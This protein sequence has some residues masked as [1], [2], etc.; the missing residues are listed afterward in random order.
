MRFLP[1]LFLASSLFAQ[2][3]AQLCGIDGVC[4][5]LDTS[6]IGGLRFEDYKVTNPNASLLNLDVRRAQ[7]VQLGQATQ[8]TLCAVN[9]NANA[10]L[11]APTL[12][13]ASAA[14]EMGESES[15]SANGTLLQEVYAQATV[16]SLSL[17][18][19]FSALQL[20][21]RI[22]RNR[23]S[24]QLVFSYGAFSLAVDQT[25][26]RVTFPTALP[27]DAQT[28]RVFWSLVVNLQNILNA[29]AAY[30]IPNPPPLGR[31]LFSADEVR[32]FADQISRAV[33]AYALPTL[34]P[35]NGDALALYGAEYL[36]TRSAT[37]A[38]VLS[39]NLTTWAKSATSA[40]SVSLKPIALFWPALQQDP[41]VP[42]ADRDAIN[43]WLT[44]LY[45]SNT[46]ASIK[47]IDAISR[48]DNQAF[49]ETVERY[50]VAINQ[51]RADGSIP[52]E[53]QRGPCALT[54][55]NIA[56]GNLISI[57]ESAAAQGYDLYSLSVNDR[58]IH[59]AIQFLLDAYD[60]FPLIA[61]Y[62][63]P[64]AS[65]YLS[66][67]A[68][69]ER[70]L[71]DPS[72]A[73]AWIEIYLARFQNSPLANRL[74]ARASLTGLTNRPL[75]NAV[76]GANTSCLFVGPQEL[77]PVSLPNLDIVSGDN[78][79]AATNS[80][81]PEKLG[82]RVR[83]NSG[84]PLPNVLVNFAVTSGAGTVDAASALTDPFGVATT[85][86]SLGPRSGATKIAASAL[87]IAPVTFTATARGDDPKLSPDGIA[88][89]GGSVPSV[90]T[91]SPGA[92]L[93]IYGADFVAAGL[94]RRVRTEEI[95]AGRLPTL[96]NGVCVL[97][98]TTLAYMLDAYPNQLNVVVPALTGTASQV[99]VVKN[100]GT[101]GEQ[102]TD[103]QAI[104]V[105]VAAP[106]F[107]SFQPTSS[108]NNPVAA[109]DAVTGEFFGPLNLFGGTAKPAK[110][111]D[112]VTVYLTGLGATT[113]AVLPGAVAPGAASVRGVLVL[114]LAG[115]TIAAENILYAGFS[116]G[117]LIYQINFRVPSG[118]PANNQPISVSVDGQSTPVGAYLTLALR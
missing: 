79:T 1:I 54:Y 39:N 35:D 117:S 81:L 25:T 82:A 114:K 2:R 76:S 106:E 89:V 19:G 56:I 24:S 80:T 51:L 98:D 116:P 97:F 60:N 61:K 113:P 47:A 94:G 22:S 107:F 109:V 26:G 45:K 27:A 72:A 48:R 57:A 3:S 74:R 102:R 105:A 6:R 93:S 34:N 52:E 73:V 83:G 50:F 16:S 36:A 92:I 30:K 43:T 100:C 59:L 104:A 96:F 99:R 42:A 78:Q 84:N 33:L 62:N 90:R 14:A 40:A 29:N 20:S 65:C 31:L 70:K 41:I 23:G 103:P 77:S 21:F 9:P 66:N 13:F 17:S 108:G 28:L 18:D 67:S 37:P 58:S 69:I 68:P 88:G 101:P 115:Q 10:I 8:T 4:V 11:S 86:L 5:A 12:R 44:P 85:R 53:A 32:A 118:L 91:A 49:A 63:N 64:S 112:Y 110:P 7:L 55:T 111:G 46:D 75:S 15:F 87:G 95:I 71:F 38:R